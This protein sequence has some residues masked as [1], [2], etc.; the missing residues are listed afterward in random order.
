M[1][2]PR[3]PPR[4]QMIRQ[5]LRHAHLRQPASS[6]SRR[7]AQQTKLTFRIAW[8]LVPGLPENNGEKLDV[9]R[10]QFAAYW[11]SAYESETTT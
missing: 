2:W 10:L 7:P 11:D 1:T 6:A 3:Q 4:R 9:V 8:N 5:H